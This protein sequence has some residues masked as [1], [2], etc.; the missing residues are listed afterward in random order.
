MNN[1]EGTKA[2]SSNSFGWVCDKIDVENFRVDRSTDEERSCWRLLKLVLFDNFLKFLIFFQLSK[3]ALT[4]L[5]EVEKF[6][7]CF[8]KWISFD[9]LDSYSTCS[10]ILPVMSSFVQIFKMLL[11]LLPRA[12]KYCGLYLLNCICNCIL[13]FCLHWRKRLL[14][15]FKTLKNLCRLKW[16]VK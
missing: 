12:R 10:V 5:H 16:Y 3:D 7:F 14:S 2:Y 4:I 9:F 15:F 11:N 8:S 1:H 13:S 6:F